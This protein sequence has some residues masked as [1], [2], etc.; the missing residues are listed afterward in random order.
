MNAQLIDKFPYVIKMLL[1]IYNYM[2][3]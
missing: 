2:K 3:I 1:G